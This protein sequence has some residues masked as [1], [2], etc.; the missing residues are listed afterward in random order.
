LSNSPGTAI[1]GRSDHGDDANLESRASLNAV[2][3]LGLSFAV[4]YG[5]NAVLL[6][7]KLE[8]LPPRD[9]GPFI[10]IMPV[11]RLA[12]EVQRAFHLP[13]LTFEAAAVGECRRSE[14]YGTGTLS[15]QRMEA[16][17]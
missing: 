9:R 5:Q 11:A 4:E 7:G 1:T 14:L 15:G 10:P 16:K 3:I 13:D 2:T 8:S 12:R 17:R 6:L